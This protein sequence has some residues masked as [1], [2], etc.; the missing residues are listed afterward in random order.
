VKRREFIAGLGS[1][2]A[3]WPLAARA[4]QRAVPV[5]GYL[6]PG[7]PDFDLNLTGFRQGLAETGFVEG[8]NV[9]IE[10]R[11][12]GGHLDRLPALAAD[13]V[14]RKAAVIVAGP[15]AAAL[16]AKAATATIPIVF[17]GG[18]DPVKLGLVA[19]LNRPG[20]NLT[21]VTN[22]ASEIESKRFELLC[23]I[24]PVAPIAVLVSRYSPSRESVVEELQAS[25]RV[26]GRQITIVTVG[27][28]DEIDSAFANFVQL[29]AGALFVAAD[30]YFNIRRDQLIALAARHKLP[31]IYFFREFVA[32]GG[33]MSY[34]ASLTDT[35][36]QVGVYVGRILK[37]LSE[38]ILS[39]MN[40]L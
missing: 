16:A 31:A 36:R 19:S 39:H 22:F 34:G 10:Y 25:A 28:E 20:G 9:A 18:G 7:T 3:A 2:A 21:G 23:A 1:A 17:T 8:R 37:C 15:N 24:V 4:Q 38:I 11:Y 29:R 27:T 5:V 40:R 6:V 33:L 30:A 14:S 26:V 12:A 35:G 13:L 32:A